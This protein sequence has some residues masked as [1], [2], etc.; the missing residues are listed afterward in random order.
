MSTPA[1]A[2]TDE[3]R[4]GISS[5]SDTGN[6][7][8]HP[9]GADVSLIAQ[10][11]TQPETG[12]VASFTFK[13]HDVAS[14]NLFTAAALH[15]FDNEAGP[16]A[17]PITGGVAQISLEDSVDNQIDALLTFPDRP[18]LLEGERYAIVFNPLLQ[19]P[20]TEDPDS[21]VSIASFVNYF[22]W[23]AHDPNFVT[24]NVLNGV[25]EG[26]STSHLIFSSQLVTSVATPEAPTLG[27]AE[28]GIVPEVV[29][30]VTE[31]ITYDVQ[32]EGMSWVITAEAAEGYE[33][34]AESATSWTL[35]FTVAACTIVPADP[36]DPGETEDPVDE[37]KPVITDKPTTEDKLVV[38]QKPAN[39][40]GT[41]ADTGVNVTGPLVMSLS[42]LLLGAGAFVATRLARV[43]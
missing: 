23:S 15:T 3:Y 20:D 16:S 9:T 30:P 24:W 29:L 35:E 19:E 27:T 13:L 5:P 34:A 10:A 38:Q 36:V 41:L 18:T 32:Q 21:E 2:A 33:L 40:K 26:Y 37:E 28:C 31:G 25:W 12:Q 4:P 8:W 1:L 42:L 22:S 39:P 6:A 11:F 17:E 7:S 43:N 14:N